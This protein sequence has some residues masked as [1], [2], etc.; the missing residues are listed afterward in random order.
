MIAIAMNAINQLTMAIAG[1][2]AISAIEQLLL[3]PLNFYRLFPDDMLLPQT[4]S[5]GLEAFFYAVFPLVLIGRMRLAATILSFAI[6]LAAYA[7]V[8]DTDLYAYRYLPGTLFIFLTGSHLQ[9]ASTALER[10]M[11]MAFYGA[12]SCLLVLA[13]LLPRFGT[14]PNQDVLVGLMIGIC[15]VT[16]LKRADRP[17]VANGLAGDLSYGIF[18]NHNLIFASLGLITPAVDADGWATMPQFILVC[19]V[20]TL[21]SYASFVALEKPLIAWRHRWRG[22]RVRTGPDLSPG[23]HSVIPGSSP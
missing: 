5:L 1:N 10:W 11:P 12:A 3:F 14:S 16:L 21:L 18:L 8:I 7:G 20:S 13:A 23:Q 9:H 4:W 17:S 22:H 2:T 6:Y 15:M 19:A